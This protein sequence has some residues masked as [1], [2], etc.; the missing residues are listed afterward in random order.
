MSGDF[1]IKW[2]SIMKGYVTVSLAYKAK[3]W[4]INAASGFSRVVTSLGLNFI[5]QEWHQEI[6]LSTNKTISRLQQILYYNIYVSG[7]LFDL[8]TSEM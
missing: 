6:K 8:K 4:F 5:V 1:I 2:Q 7:L 3:S